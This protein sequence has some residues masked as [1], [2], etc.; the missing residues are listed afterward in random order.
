MLAVKQT[1]FRTFLGAAMIC[2]LSVSAMG[3][4]IQQ[5]DSAD[6]TYKTEMDGSGQLK[7]NDNGTDWNWDK[8]NNGGTNTLSGGILTYDSI[9]S[10]KNDWWV[11]NTFPS[12]DKSEGFTVEFSV[13]AIDS[14]NDIAIQ[15]LTSPASNI[16]RGVTYIGLNHVYWNGTTSTNFI[17]TANN[18][19]GFHV[20]RI[21]YDVTAAKYY[22]WRDGVL[23]GDDLTGANNSAAA[24]NFGDATGSFAGSASIDYIRWTTGAYAPVPEPGSLSLLGLGGLL[25]LRRRKTRI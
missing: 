25:M 16:A 12:A 10:V 7:I 6:F 3:A 2:G 23:I 20:F 9:N 22:I 11:S 17:S 13:K 19:D 4:I 8:D 21:A 1:G 5:M 15:F 14:D 24:L 18:K